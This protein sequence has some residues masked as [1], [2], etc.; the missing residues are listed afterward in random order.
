EPDDGILDVLLDLLR[1]LVEVVER[2]G[3]LVPGPADGHQCRAQQHRRQDETQAKRGHEYDLRCRFLVPDNA[4]YERGQ[5]APC[6]ERPPWRSVFSWGRFAIG[7][8]PPR[9]VEEANY[10]FAPREEANYKFAPREEAERHGGRSRQRF[11]PAPAPGRA[12][13]SALPW[14]RA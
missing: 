13:R 5:S 7:H 3:L 10:K 8:L 6:G 9:G 1:Q 14:R 4:R 2:L 12:A 11:T